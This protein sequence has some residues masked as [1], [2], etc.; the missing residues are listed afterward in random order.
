MSANIYVTEPMTSGKVVLHTTVGPLDVELWSTQVP[1]A[2]RN[3]IQL[4]MEGYYDNTIFHRIV[5]DYLVQGGDPTGTGFG[6]DSV[7]EGPFKDEFHSRLRFSHRGLVACASFDR[8][9]NGS[10]FFI[11]LDATPELDKKHTIFGKITGDTIYN[12][13][14]LN[15][16]EADKDDRPLKPP[17]VFRAEILWNPFEDIVPREKPKEEVKEEPEPEIKPPLKKNLSLLSFGDEAEDDDENSNFV[18]MAIISKKAAQ[19]SSA[20]KKT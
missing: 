6:G 16:F 17:Q 3:F 10:Q 18:P 7:Y 19:N 11:T 12:L 2:C 9:K 1:K 14:R 20:K 4:C 5:K 8:D 13:I 15:S